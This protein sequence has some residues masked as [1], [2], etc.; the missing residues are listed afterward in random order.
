MLMRAYALLD[1]AAETERAS[2]LNSVG[3]AQYEAE[4]ASFDAQSEAETASHSVDKKHNNNNNHMP[5]Q[6]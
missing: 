5:A 1:V 3:A 4:A 6:P 2:F